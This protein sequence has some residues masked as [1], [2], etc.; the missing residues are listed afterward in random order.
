LEKLDDVDS[1]KDAEVAL[2]PKEYRLLEYFTQ[3]EGRALTRQRILDEVWGEDLI[4][5]ERSVNRC[6]NTLRNKIEPDPQD[7]PG[8]RLPL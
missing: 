8:Y 4:V 1:R 2:T 7:D 5:T 3:N 6:I